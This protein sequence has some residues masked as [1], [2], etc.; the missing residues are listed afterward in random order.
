MENRIDL[1]NVASVPQSQKSCGNL[2]AAH[3]GGGM[4]MGKDKLLLQILLHPACRVVDFCA[5]F[6]K[7]EIDK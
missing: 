5:L 2:T 4:G 1:F 3:H 6:L 7:F